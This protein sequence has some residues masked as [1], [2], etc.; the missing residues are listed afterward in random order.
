MAWGKA[1]LPAESS[2][3]AHKDGQQP[4]AWQEHRVFMVE[5]GRRTAGKDVLTRAPPLTQSTT[6][7]L[8]KDIFTEM[9]K[10]FILI[11]ISDIFTLSVNF[12]DASYHHNNYACK[13]C[14]Y[15]YGSRGNIEEEAVKKFYAFLGPLLNL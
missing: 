12:D 10:M 2:P 7:I 3:F 14:I 5:R 9:K 11:Y 8:L 15:L 1:F 4:A 6:Y 13:Y